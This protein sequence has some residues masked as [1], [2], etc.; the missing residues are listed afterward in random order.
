MEVDILY[1]PSKMPAAGKRPLSCGLSMTLLHARRSL[2]VFVPPLMAYLPW[3]VL[4]GYEN[5]PPAH[6]QSQPAR[7]KH[8]RRLPRRQ[9]ADVT[10]FRKRRAM[11]SLRPSSMELRTRSRCVTTLFSIY[12]PFCSPHRNNLG[13][14]VRRGHAEILLHH[15]RRP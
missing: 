8:H 7:P 10:E 4:I 15:G 14:L 11:S 2:R 1:S 3:S 6:P 5:P 12:S 13:A 9:N